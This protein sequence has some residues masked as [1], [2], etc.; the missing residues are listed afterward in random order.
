MNAQPLATKR[1]TGPA[2]LLALLPLLLAGLVVLYLV[3][4]GGGLG[5]LA[6]PPVE[7]LNISRITLPQPGMIRV[8]VVNEGPETV[9]IAQVT[10]DEAYWAFQAEPGTTVPRLGRTVLTIPYPWVPEEAHEVTLITRLGTT[11][12]AGIP[13]A[14]PSPH[15]SLRLFLR[16]GL[17]GFYVGIVPIF[18]GLLWYPFLQRLSQQATRFLLSLTAGLLGYLAIA[19]WLDALAFAH[20]LPAFWQ[21]GP[22]V[23]FIALLSLGVLLVWGRR[24][25]E[26]GTPLRLAY[27][28]ALGIGLHNLGEGL[29]IG[30]AFALGQAALGTFLILGF[31]LHNLTEGIGI[32]VPVVKENP[33]I[34]HFGLLLL[35]AGAPAILGTWIGG[36]AYNP[37]L[38]TL[39]LA[40]GVGAI[41]QVIGEVGKLVARDSRRFGQSP[42]SWT[43]LGGI[44][45]GFALMYVTAFLIK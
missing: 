25:G 10:V 15:P 22:L 35:L 19:T 27:Q 12:S 34:K 18:L 16:F 20:T 33:G 21:G 28:I 24:R 45:S 3:L 38:A 13:A 9:T 30:A 14:V 23:L 5:E 39:F 8:E 36:F 44:V 6:G 42:L 31:T 7:R 29:A 43:N 32:A 1:I 40:V 37:V 26:R 17:V 41:L 11:F 4:S 2:W